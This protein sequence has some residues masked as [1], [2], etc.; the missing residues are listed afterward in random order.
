M[1][2]LTNKMETDKLRHSDITIN[3]SFSKIEANQCT[4]RECIQDSD[5]LKIDCNKC[6]RILHYA[7]TGLPPYQLKLFTSK[8]YRKYV[9]F[10]CVSVNKDFDE[11]MHKQANKINYNTHYHKEIK[12]CE[13]TI[14]AKTDSENRLSC[15]MKDLLPNRA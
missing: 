2:F 11:A 5:K 3:Q 14:K 4:E 13:N 1:N 8:G 15:R 7:C 9:C 12:G 6:H 10:N